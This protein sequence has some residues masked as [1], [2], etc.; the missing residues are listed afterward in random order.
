LVVPEPKQMVGAMDIFALVKIYADIVK[1]LFGVIY[2]FVRKYN[3]NSYSI[4]LYLNM[5]RIIKAEIDLNESIKA[6]KALV[7]VCSFLNFQNLGT[8]ATCHKVWIKKARRNLQMK[9]KEVTG[10]GL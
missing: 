4:S 8:V 1:Q 3:N 7:R 9:L 2:A 5:N 6:M 10:L